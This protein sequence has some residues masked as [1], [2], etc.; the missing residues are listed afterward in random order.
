M[1]SGRRMGRPPKGEKYSEMIR[2]NYRLHPSTVKTLK[3]AARRFEIT[4]TEYVE[5]ALKEKFER[6]G[7]IKSETPAQ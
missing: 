2:V 1:M 3:K 5:Q 4:Q 7:I 6:D